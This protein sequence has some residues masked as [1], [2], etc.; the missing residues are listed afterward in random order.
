MASDATQDATLYEWKYEMPGRDDAEKQGGG[1][2]VTVVFRGRLVISTPFWR[3]HLFTAESLKVLLMV[4]EKYVF[5]SS[6]EGIL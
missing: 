5:S 3:F 4:V 1:D 2:L 6:K